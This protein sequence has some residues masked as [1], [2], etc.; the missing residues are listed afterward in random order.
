MAVYYIASYDIA[1]RKAF[2]P[3]VPQVL[4][5]LQKHGGEIVVADNRAQALE[6]QARDVTV[7]LRFESENALRAFYAD[8]AYA[9]VKKIRLA[10]TRNGTAVIAKQ[11]AAAPV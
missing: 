6:G 8:P 10:S 3:Y 4:P 1:D 7:I 9:P 5:L 2:E 11:F